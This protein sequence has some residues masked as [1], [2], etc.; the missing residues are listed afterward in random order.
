M[1]IRKMILSLIIFMAINSTTKGQ[2]YFTKNG[3]ISFFSKTILQN[4][5]ADN[6]EVIS[7]LN[8]QTGVFT[9]LITQYCFSFSQSKN[10]RRL[11]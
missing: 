10:G 8:I 4:I 9:I 5:Q 6:N 2:V 11:Q 3:S 7:I 1:L